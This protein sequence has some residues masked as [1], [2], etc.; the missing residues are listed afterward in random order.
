MKMSQLIWM[1]VF[2]V[3]LGFSVTGVVSAQNPP[4]GTTTVVR[5][6]TATDPLVSSGGSTPN[7]SLTPGAVVTAVTATAPLVSSGGDTPVISLPGV[8]IAGADGRSAP[9]I[10]LGTLIKIGSTPPYVA[11]GDGASRGPYSTATRSV[12]AACGIEFAPLKK[13]NERKK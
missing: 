8:T 9:S 1:M 12:H 7:I 4:P 6:V 3:V 13:T 2:A 5:D 11:I 10:S